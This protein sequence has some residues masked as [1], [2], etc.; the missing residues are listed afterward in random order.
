MEVEIVSQPILTDSQQALLG[1]HSIVNV[2]K[3]ILREMQSLREQSRDP[4]VF[5]LSTKQCSDVLTWLGDKE[6]S[7]LALK[8]MS[9]FYEILRGDLKAFVVS[10]DSWQGNMNV[11]ESLAN[12]E[13]LL[14]VLVARA[15]ELIAGENM[16]V[17]WSTVK[18]DSIRAEI[19]DF[20]QA[21][22]LNSKGGYRIVFSPEDK[23]EKDFLFLIQIS[24]PREGEID[25]PS[26]LSSIIRDLVANARK[27]SDLGGVIYIDISSDGIFLKLS[28][29]NNGRGIPEQDLPR[30]VN[31]GERGSNVGDRPTMGQGFG[32]TKSW[33]E[34]R[35]MG[36]R[37]WIFSEV[38]KNTK[39][40]IEIPVP[41]KAEAGTGK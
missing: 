23:G 15:S 10:S 28:V 33:V 1:K 17:I 27:Y 9:A 12:L 19:V 18:S 5:S 21:I 36:G 16:G 31:F 25:I 20:A 14:Y 29:E 3:L 4:Q 37:M 7:H 13:S 26:N 39:I 8:E 11:C 30:G 34:T 40:S 35:K 41:R 38:G 22:E 32:L 24:S 6:R 2:L